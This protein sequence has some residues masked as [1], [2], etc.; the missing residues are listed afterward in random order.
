MSQTMTPPP[1]NLSPAATADRAGRPAAAGDGLT[2]RILMQGTGSILLG[3]A[4]GLTAHFIAAPRAGDF[5]Q[6]MIVIGLFV[7]GGYLMFGPPRHKRIA[8]QFQGGF[9]DGKTLTGDL[10]SQAQGRAADEAVRHYFTT[11]RGTVGKR[12][13]SASQYMIDTLRT[14]GGDVAAMRAA[15]RDPRFQC[16]HYEVV[17]RREKDGE[18]LIRVKY[19][20]S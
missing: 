9:M 14:H 18:I 20:P 3:A 10:K 12:F 4:L 2:K 1:E 7:G 13:W 6:Y 19:I 16:D 11:D 5:F 8:F 17:E 15:S